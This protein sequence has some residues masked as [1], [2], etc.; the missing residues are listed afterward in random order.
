[1]RLQWNH[2]DWWKRL[3]DSTNKNIKCMK[4]D[5]IW[6][7]WQLRE[8][9]VMWMLEEEREERLY[10]RDKGILVIEDKDNMGF[11]F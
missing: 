2:S 3:N 1:M 8:R 11:L 10:K 7:V 6:I 5:R 9:R 4:N